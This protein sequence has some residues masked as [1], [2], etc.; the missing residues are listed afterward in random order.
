M[1]NEDRKTGFWAVLGTLNVIVITYTLALYLRAEVSDAQVFAG[2][3]L[4]GA[5]FLLVIVDTVS[6]LIAYSGEAEIAT[7][8][9]GA[10]CRGS[11]WDRNAQARR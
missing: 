3:V 2:T 11:Q 6:I 8:R 7:P 4:L 5:G 9:S 1:R 10:G